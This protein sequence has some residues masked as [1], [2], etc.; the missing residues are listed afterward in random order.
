MK[1]EELI[2]GRWYSGLERFVGGIGLWTGEVF[3]GFQCK[4]GMYLETGMPF[5]D[6]NHFKLLELSE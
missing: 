4:F 6:G 2:K 5:H 3:A 1:R